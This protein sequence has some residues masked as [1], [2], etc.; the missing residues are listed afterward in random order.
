[1]KRVPRLLFWAL[2]GLLLLLAPSFWLLAAAQ[3]IE[4]RWLLDFDRGGRVELTLERRGGHRS[5][6]HSSD[7]RLE[8][9][10]G[11]ARPEGTAETPVSF[12]LVRDAGTFVFEGRLDQSGG[13]GRF[14]FAANPDFVDSMARMGYSALTPDQISSLALH[15]IG[16]K[17]V[18]ELKALGYSTVPVDDLISMG[19]H[20][21][22]PEFIRELKALGYERLAV[23]DL[24][25]MCIH[26]ATPAFIREMK[27]LGYDRLAADELVSMRI[28]E[29]T[30]EFVR[31]MTSLGYPL[32]PGDDLVS[33]RI[34][35]VTPEF[36]RQLQA[37]GYRDIPVDELVSMKIHGV[38]IEFVR[39]MKAALP[40][41]SADDLVGLRV[42]D[43]N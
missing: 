39:Q 29:V 21:A 41:A 24:V 30:P 19:I 20:G 22:T 36:V 10:R 2:V 38:T 34:H 33:M 26:E 28:H 7:Y 15:D 16:R 3:P 14:S 5:W 31:E 27:G 32:V 17:F 13:S 18:T 25:S 40:N 43:R 1:M 12:E 11:L 4:G 23:D 42:R 6:N 9:F 8:D 35:D 37:L